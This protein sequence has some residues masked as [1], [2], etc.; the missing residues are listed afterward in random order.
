MSRIIEVAAW[1]GAARASV[2]FV[3][4]LGGHAYGTWRRKPDDGSFWPPW[5]AEDLPG[6]RVLTLAY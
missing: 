4:G 6:L 3:H 5:L 1:A 2:V